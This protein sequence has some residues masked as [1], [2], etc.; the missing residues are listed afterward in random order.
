MSFS[1]TTWAGH[2]LGSAGPR[3]GSRSRK[4]VSAARNS[5]SV[6]LAMTPTTRMARATD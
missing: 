4:E 3:A 2:G 5:G 6:K 1:G